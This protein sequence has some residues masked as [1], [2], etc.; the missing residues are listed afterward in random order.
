MGESDTC[1]DAGEADSGRGDEKGDRLAW[2]PWIVAGLGG[3]IGLGI[4]AMQFFFPSVGRLAGAAVLAFWGLG[5]GALAWAAEVHQRAAAAYKR[6]GVGLASVLLG[7]F[8]GVG[9]GGGPRDEDRLGSGTTVI[10]T[11]AQPTQSTTSTAPVAPVQ[12]PFLS[13]IPDIS[14]MNLTVA[15]AD[16]DGAPHIKSFVAKID[17]AQCGETSKASLYTAAVPRGT[18]RFDVRLGDSS[19]SVTNS[20]HDQ[21]RRTTRR[22]HRPLAPRR[23]LSK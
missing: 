20:A 4:P 17:G 21:R 18:L 8:I 19:P 13:D 11:G 5:G 12:S 1:F 10:S 2:L 3:G 7:I 16:V 23:L 22:C 14:M 6:M 15:S 9:S